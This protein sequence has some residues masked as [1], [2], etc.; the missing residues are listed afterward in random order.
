[1]SDIS[2]LLGLK[3][4]HKAPPAKMRNKPAPVRLPQEKAMKLEIDTV[5]EYPEGRRIQP[6]MYDDVFNQLKN[7]QSVKTDPGYKSTSRIANAMKN[8]LK[9]T[10][11]D[12]TLRAAMVSHMP[13]GRGRVFLMRRKK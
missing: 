3:K 4:P 12:A 7:G 13:D 2:M 1:M 5:T 10:G 6:G 11:K 8:W 9:R